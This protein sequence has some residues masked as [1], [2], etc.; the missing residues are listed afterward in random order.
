MN[1]M[2]GGTQKAASTWIHGVL[3]VSGL[4]AP[5]RKEWHYW[6]RA[7]GMWQTPRS[8]G[9]AAE[10]LDAVTPGEL[11]DENSVALSGLPPFRLGTHFPDRRRDPRRYFPVPT[12]ALDQWISWMNIWQ[13]GDFTPSNAV[14]KRHHWQEISDNLP[15]LHVIVGVRNP[16]MRLWSAIR[17]Y[18]ER[19]GFT[20]PFEP[21]DALRFAATPG[22]RERSRISSTIKTLQELLPANRLLIVSLDEVARRPKATVGRLAQF[23]KTELALVP[24][25]NVGISEPIPREIFYALRAYFDDELAE[26]QRIVQHDLVL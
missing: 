17:H 10:F 16:T 20:G 2:Y 7:L 8:G 12:S 19:G 13:V 14:L 23:V 9:S 21:K 1:L 18:K 26:L 22:H 6:D 3:T 11:I 15:N 24:P 5:R 25:Q 4:S